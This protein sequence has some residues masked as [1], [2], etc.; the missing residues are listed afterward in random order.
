MAYATPARPGN[1]SS[2]APSTTSAHRAS[3]PRT[4]T[5]SATVIPL[6]TRTFSG[7]QGLARFTLVAGL[8]L[9]IPNH[10]TIF[11]SLRIGYR[12]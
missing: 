6:G 4:R 2:T 1:H 3:H 5:A 10:D 11:I 8:P 7:W 12:T 9:F